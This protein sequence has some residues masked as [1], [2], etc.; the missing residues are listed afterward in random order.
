MA[1]RASAAIRISTP[2]PVLEALSK[3]VLEA[4]ENPKTKDALLKQNFVLI[5]TKSPE[6]AQQFLREELKTWKE[7]I[8]EV[9]IDIA[10]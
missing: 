2:K 10:E 3:A 9:K 4:L 6:E 5:P 1:R 7:L 8:K